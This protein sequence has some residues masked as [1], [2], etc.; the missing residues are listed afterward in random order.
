MPARVRYKGSDP[1]RVTWPPGVVFPSDREYDEVIEPGHQLP[2]NAPAGLRDQLL[3][4][5]KDGDERFAAVEETS[6]KDKG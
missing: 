6:S 3:Q 1:L 4:A 2:S 5:A